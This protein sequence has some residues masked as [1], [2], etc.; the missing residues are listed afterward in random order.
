MIIIKKLITSVAA[1]GILLKV[2]FNTYDLMTRIVVILFLVFAVTLGMKN[3]LIIMNQ[4]ALA[5][6]VGKVYVVAFLIYWFGFLIYWDYSSFMVG[7]YTKILFS[8]PFWLGGIYFTYK[9]L[10]KKP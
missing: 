8:V 3:V 10:I 1:V 2:F 5:I 4:K 6:K 9:R 7:N